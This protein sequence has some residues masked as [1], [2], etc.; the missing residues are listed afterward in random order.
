MRRRVA[1]QLDHDAHALAVRLVVEPLDADDPFFLVRFDDRLDD[2]RRRHLVRNLADDDLEAAAFFD[3]LRFAAQRHRTAPRLVGLADRFFA[4]QNPAG[5]K[6]GAVHDV[7]QRV[8]DLVVGQVRAAG[9]VLD[10]VRDR[11]ADLTDVVRRDV[12]RHADRD[13]RAA[14]DEQLRQ[15]RGQHDRLF[16]LVVEVGDEIDGLF[17]DV[18]QHVERRP[19]ET[20]FRVPVRG[21]RVGRGR[22]EV[23]VTVHQRIAQREVLRHAHERVVHRAVAVRVVALEHLAD[24]AGGLAVLLGRVEPHLAHRVQNP[25]LHGLEAVAHVGKGPRS[26]DRHGIGEVAL[27]HLVFDGDRGHPRVVWVHGYFLRVKWFGFEAVGELG[28]IRCHGLLGERRALAQRREVRVVPRI[29]LRQMF[30]G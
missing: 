28:R 13:A 1:R 29:D 2:A 16:G 27:P 6:I 25:P 11:V 20:R 19:R 14:V 24:D 10:Q 7:A 18:R 21:R 17:V 15:A 23:A 5:R 12:R 4:H 9:L 30:G 8:V 26:D 3:D 22:T